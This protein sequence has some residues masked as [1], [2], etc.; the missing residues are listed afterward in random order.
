VEKQKFPNIV[1]HNQ[2][3]K[4]YVKTVPIDGNYPGAIIGYWNLL[5]REVNGHFPMAR[6][7][8]KVTT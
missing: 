6:S 8:T 4:S 7:K 1:T 3:D 5:D 2:P